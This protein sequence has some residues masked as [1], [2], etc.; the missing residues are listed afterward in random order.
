MAGNLRNL[1]LSVNKLRVL[2]SSIGTFK[3]LKTLNLSRN[4]LTQLPTEFQVWYWIR[5]RIGIQPKM[6]DPDRYFGTM[7]L[8]IDWYRYLLIVLQDLVKLEILNVSFN[9]LT[10]VEDVFSKLKNLK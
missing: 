8:K 10:A 4:S 1:D 9:H 7:A 6:P 2:P 5:I 3:L